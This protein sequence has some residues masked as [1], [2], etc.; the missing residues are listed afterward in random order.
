M[1]IKRLTLLKG[2]IISGTL[3]G[4]LS[5]LNANAGDFLRTSDAVPNSYIVVLKSKITKSLAQPTAAKAAVSLA[6]KYAV[7]SNF[8]YEHSISGFSIKASEEQ[9]RSLAQDASVAYVVEDGIASISAIQSSPTWGLDR[10]DQRSRQLNRSYIYDQTG[11]GVNAYVLDTGIRSTHSEFNGRVNLDFTSIADGRGASDCNGHGTHVAGT[12]GGSTYGVAKRVRLHSVRVLGCDGSGTWSGV[13]AGIDWV[14]THAAAPA[15]ANM[16]LQGGK[17]RAVDD[18]VRRS[19]Q[20]GVTYVFAAGNT[21]QNACNFSPSGTREGITV[22]ATTSTDSR[23]SFSNIGT[24]VDLFAPGSS[25]LSSWMSGDNATK[26]LNGTSMA[27]PH[28]T[29]T[30]ALYLE[31]HTNASPPGVNNALLQMTTYGRVSGAGANTPNHL[32]FS[33][34]S[35]IKRAPFF[36][37]FNRGNGDHFYTSSWNELGGAGFSNWK[38]EGV[39]GYLSPKFIANTTALYRYFNTR[40]GDHFYTTNWG[41]LGSA[42]SNGWRYEGVAGY[43]PTY[44]SSDTAQLFRYFNTSSGDHFYTTNWN[45]LGAGG[46]GNWVYEGVQ[47]LIFTAP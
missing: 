13:I 6:S 5:A 20:S 27:A 12:I 3:V 30:V 4:S 7:E 41:E 17:N 32:L 39:Q 8:I 44:N 16:S 24:C 34:N 19:I 37:Y 42:G 31:N 25:I 46:S 15:V 45:E 9:A 28:V 29:G 26:T 40:N 47:C 22:A 33:R 2:I 23:S 14:T 18:A 38:Y 43:V 10:I 36:R 21:G 1:R 35:T 11:D